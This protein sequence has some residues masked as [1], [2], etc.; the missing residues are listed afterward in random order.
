MQS[1][2][3]N[4]WNKNYISI[5]KGSLLNFCEENK[6]ENCGG[7]QREN[8]CWIYDKNKYITEKRF[9][10]TFGNFTFGF[11]EDNTYDYEWH[12]EDYLYYVPGKVEYYCFGLQAIR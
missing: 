4:N 2:K 1:K 6:I 7:S 12:P 9:F 3:I 10:A 5:I 8:M 11:G